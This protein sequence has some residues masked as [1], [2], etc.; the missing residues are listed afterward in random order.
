MCSV[1]LQKQ[2]C[3]GIETKKVHTVNKTAR[4]GKIIVS[5]TVS[6]HLHVHKQRGPNFSTHTHTYK[7]SK[8]GIK[9]HEV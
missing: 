7:I 8:V 2:N 4:R 3:T 6:A 5:H 9:V 1:R